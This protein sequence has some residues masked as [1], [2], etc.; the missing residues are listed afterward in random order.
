MNKS[1]TSTALSSTTGL[2]WS[3]L[4]AQGRRFKKPNPN[5]YCLNIKFHPDD[6]Y[7][8]PVK[9]EDGVTRVIDNEV[10]SFCKNCGWIKINNSG[11]VD[12]HT[13]NEHKAGKCCVC[14]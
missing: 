14:I 9:H 11:G 5:V 1:T 6:P 2:M 3:A 13:T 4:R 12:P 7:Q 8:K 10:Y